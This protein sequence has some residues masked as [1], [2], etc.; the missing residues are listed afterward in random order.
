MLT[1]REKRFVA[2]LIQDSKKLSAQTWPEWGVWLLFAFGGFL[3]VLGCLVT[4]NNLN[5]LS[6]K[7]M[8]LPSVTGGIIFLLFGAYGIHMSKKIE[9]QMFL[10]GVLKKLIV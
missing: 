9:E 1:F 4:V 7:F 8:L 2:K 10:A 5:A 3:I 6:I